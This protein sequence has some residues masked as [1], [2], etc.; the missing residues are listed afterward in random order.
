MVLDSKSLHML[1]KHTLPFYLF[2]GN[3]CIFNTNN[4][5]KNELRLFNYNSQVVVRFDEH[6]NTWES[7]KF[8]IDR[9][10]EH[11][12]DYS[13]VC[14][15][16]FVIVFG[17]CCN[18]THSSSVKVY[19]IKTKRWKLCP[20][21]LPGFYFKTC[22]L[23]NADN[24]EIHIIGGISRHIILGQHLKIKVNDIIQMV[25]FSFDILK[26]N[27]IQQQLDGSMSLILSY[28]IFYGK[29][30]L[31]DEGKITGCFLVNLMQLNIFVVLCNVLFKLDSIKCKKICFYLFEL[32]DKFFCYKKI[33]DRFFIQK[34]ANNN[35]IVIVLYEDFNHLCVDKDYP[36]DAFEEAILDRKINKFVEITIAKD[37]T[38]LVINYIDKIN[39]IDKVLKQITKIEEIYQIID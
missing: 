15:D 19:C 10:L 35:V 26:N 9:E 2:V 4:D 3:H 25:E 21:K 16:G 37:K 1:A 6:N 20:H 36:L 34:K 28:L 8:K 29:N 7:T 18:G 38:K 14:I 33:L 24:T 30:T 17:G 39:K 23:L 11:V 31:F 5:N 32:P 12:F 22:A 27:T 13:F